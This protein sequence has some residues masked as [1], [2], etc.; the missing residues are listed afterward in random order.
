MLSWFVLMAP[1][2]SRNDPSGRELKEELH[3]YKVTSQKVQSYIEATGTVQPDLEGGAKIISPLQGTV[4]RVFVKIGDRVA[5]GDQLA[6]LRS[7]DVSDTY[8]SHLSSLAQL[9]QAERV[10]KLNKELFEIG[11][12]TK[13]DLLNSEASYE[14]AKAL[15]EGL[16]KKL[17]IYGVSEKG[18]P[19][20]LVLK[21]PIA[22]FIADIPAHIGDRFDASTPLMIIANPGKTIVVA[23]IY[24][25]DVL[26]IHKGEEV[27][28]SADIFPDTAFKGEISYVSDVE[29]MDSKTVKTYIKNVTGKGLFKQN[30]F[31]KI[32]ILSEEKE[33]PVV[34]KT[35]IIYKDGKFYVNLKKGR[36]F[37]LKEVKSVKDV[38]DK[39]MTVEGLHEGDEIVYSAI[40]M[41]KP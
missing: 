15:S 35:A 18:F 4:E 28:F 14:Q 20:T 24:D 31:I 34:P 25:S 7:S 16:E 1:G 3:T 9:R 29:D 41:E 8:A 37:E 13:N 10:Y 17:D 21:A 22:G 11:A 6:A 27:T 40:D 23:N 39:L 30:M 2:C 12:V 33:L 26:K 36:Q 32:R 5:K 38:S 19:A